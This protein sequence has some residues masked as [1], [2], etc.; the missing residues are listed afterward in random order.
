MTDGEDMETSPMEQVKLAKEQ[1][2]TIFTVGIGTPEG[3]QIRS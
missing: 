2:V 1:G 3:G